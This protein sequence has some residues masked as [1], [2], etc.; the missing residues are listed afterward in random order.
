MPGSGSAKSIQHGVA[1]RRPATVLAAA[2][3]LCAVGC[4]T[5]RSM[6]LC[7]VI[8]DADLRPIGGATV[9]IQPYAPIHPFWPAAA[10]GV[11]DANG[12]VRLSLPSDF[13]FNFCDVRAAGYSPSKVQDRPIEPA[14]REY[15]HFLFCMHRDSADGAR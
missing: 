10:S 15:P 7:R 3:L 6:Q 11:T 2:G 1:R 8:D 12:E 14:G 13:W 5:P 4:Q 9:H